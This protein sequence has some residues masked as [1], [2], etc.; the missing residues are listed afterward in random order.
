MTK[1]V[2]NMKVDLD[3]H[4]VENITARYLQ[5]MYTEA[6]SDIAK[7]IR[8]RINGKSATL[9]EWEEYDKLHTNSESMRKMLSAILEYDSYTM[10]LDIVY[11]KFYPI[12]KD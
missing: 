12:K 7:F 11:N 4:T 5:E 10:F 3:I 8:D 1:H 6:Q 9:A 2:K